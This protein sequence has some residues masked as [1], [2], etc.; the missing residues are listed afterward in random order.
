MPRRPVRPAGD[1]T[2]IPPGKSGG[3]TG[4][5]AIWNYFFWQAL[6]TNN[7]DATGKVLR[8]AAVVNECS[9]YTVKPSRELL[10]RCNQF[11]G[12]TQPGVTTP[13]PTRTEA[14]A[15]QAGGDR[16]RRRSAARQRERQDRLRDSLGDLLGDSPSGETAPAPQPAPTAPLP[17]LPVPSVPTPSVPVP[18]TPAPAPSGGGGGQSGLPLL[19]WLLGGG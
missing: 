16:D 3:F 1:K 18:T 8:L 15:A 10:A 19:D 7:M 2:H 5:E 14:D 6:T 9:P 17:N 11:L 4:Y 13:D 12:P